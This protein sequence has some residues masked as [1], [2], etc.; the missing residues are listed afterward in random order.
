MSGKREADI[1]LIGTVKMML[2]NQVEGIE[3]EAKLNGVKESIGAL[4]LTRLE[5]RENLKLFIADNIDIYKNEIKTEEV[6]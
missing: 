3:D 6:L 1:M 2:A 5:A 4:T